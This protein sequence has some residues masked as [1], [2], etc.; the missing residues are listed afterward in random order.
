MEKSK[1]RKVGSGAKMLQFAQSEFLGFW[2]G[3]GFLVVFL[4]F[5]GE[6][7]EF[8]IVGEFQNFSELLGGGQCQL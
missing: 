6:R 2:G 5:E 8:S 7:K 3:L 4:F 1:S